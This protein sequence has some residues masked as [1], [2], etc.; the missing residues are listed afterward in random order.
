MRAGPPLPA[1]SAVRRLA[2]VCAALLLAIT[3]VSAFIRLSRAGMGCEP[4][5][6]C[7]V[8]RAQRP[9]ALSEAAGVMDAPAVTAA[10]LA[11][12]VS[13]S[14]A[15]LL[16]IAL[17]FKA[18]ARRPPLRREGR[19]ALSL[20]TLSL[21]L[22]ALGRMGGGSSAVAV[23]LGNLLGGFA[24]LVLSLR[25]ALRP[26]APS[27]PVAR[28]SGLA[29]A[30]LLLLAGQAALGGWAAATQ[31]GAG[32]GGWGLCRWH[33][34]AALPVAGALLALAR[35]TWRAGRAGAAVAVVAL[36][37]MQAALGLWQASS[38]PL[39]LALALAHNVGA[40]LLLAAA[41][42]LIPAAPA[43]VFSV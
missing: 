37:A 31:A 13:A 6:A 38:A 9:V 41:A 43:R 17:L 34:L 16:V 42:L 30:A 7:Y 35:Q 10:R 3:S 39:P 40:A 11:H 18:L 8:Q 33:A 1:A 24:M 4:W 27:E 2:W 25:L 15:L 21:F 20:L 14:A 28:A 12:R 19:L 36:L 26:A 29:W 5:P 32:C 22:A 23:T